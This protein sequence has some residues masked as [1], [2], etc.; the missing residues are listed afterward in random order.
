MEWT[1]GG[2]AL[3]G[4]RGHFGQFAGAAGGQQQPR[5]LGREGQRSGRANAGAG[6]GDEDNLPF[7]ALHCP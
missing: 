4:A 6:S 3:Q 1:A 5:S 2:A 7:Q